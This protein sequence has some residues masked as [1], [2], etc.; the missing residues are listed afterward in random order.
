MVHPIECLHKKSLRSN[1]TSVTG[2]LTRTSNCRY[3]CEQNIP[4]SQL[5]GAREGFAT[6]SS[7][8]LIKA[9]PLFLLWSGTT[10]QT[11]KGKRTA[12]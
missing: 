3:N 5:A 6:R 9:R 10:E 7:I 12:D 4:Y 1:E 2:L 8:W 11:K